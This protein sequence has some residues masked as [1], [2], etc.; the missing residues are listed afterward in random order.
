MQTNCKVVFSFLNHHYWALFIFVYWMCFIFYFIHDTSTSASNFQIF[1]FIINI[2]VTCDAC[3]SLVKG[4]LWKHGCTFL[5]QMVHW[6]PA[7]IVLTSNQVYSIFLIHKWIWMPGVVKL[8]FQFLLDFELS[9]KAVFNIVWSVANS[10][11]RRAKSYVESLHS[12][13]KY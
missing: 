11:C 3:K 6:H 1:Y 7:G 12:P 4:L 13:N 5:D 8:I 2:T 9:L 10:E